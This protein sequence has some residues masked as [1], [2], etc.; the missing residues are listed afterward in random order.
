MTTRDTTP[1]DPW[2]R[3][4]LGDRF[5][6]RTIDLG[7]DPDGEGPISASLVR[8]SAA[9]ADP[10]L[11]ILFVHGLS[12]YFFHSHVAVDLA[13]RGL[14]LY[15]L[16]LRKSGRARHDGLTPHFVSDL[17]LY[18]TELDASLDIIAEDHPGT[19]VVICAHSTGG[20]VTA[21]WLSRRRDQSRLEPVRGLVL[22]SPW[23]DL[24]LSPTLRRVVD[25]AVAALSIRRPLYQIPL[26]TS[27]LYAKSIHISGWGD[28]D[29]DTR[30]KPFGGVGIRAGWLRAVRLGHKRLH[31]GL[32]LPL[33]VL[34]LRSS[35]S[36]IGRNK[37]LEPD[38]D[39]DLV[40]DVESMRRWLPKVAP[41]AVDVPLDGARHDVFL[42]A[43]V[44]RRTALD[45]LG[46]W[47]ADIAAG[48]DE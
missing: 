23:F 16:D 18:D 26:A 9:P 46:E 20:L 17:E 10:S 32:D 36:S 38:V 29:F 19:G 41:D 37:V 25:P 13:D 44:V 45:R 42:S 6:E 47:L 30:L 14:A 22:N 33:P 43:K 3:D 31:E 4:I 7:L 1:L 12:D 2:Q 11:V 21:L 28:F 5:E 27:D 34:Q 8:D 39:A 40:L 24:D 35:R 48:T 15:A